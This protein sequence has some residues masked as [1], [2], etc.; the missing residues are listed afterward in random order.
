ALIATKPATS[1]GYILLADLYTG[2]ERAKE[3]IALLE[4]ATRLFPN[5]PLILLAKS[6]A[7]LVMGKQQQAYDCL[8]EAFISDALDID[9]KAGVLYTAVS[10]NSKS[11]DGKALTN[12]SDLLV[13][14]YPR[15]AKA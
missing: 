15:E 8:E 2:E 4:D 3:A 13:E 11:L 10:R 1:K 7:Y 9:A 12:L 14:A 6:D 5:D